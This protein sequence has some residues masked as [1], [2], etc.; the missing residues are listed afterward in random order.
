MNKLEEILGYNFK[1]PQLL[2]QALTHSSCTGNVHRNYERLE[3]LGDRVLG[4]AIA[5][6]L[7]QTFP[8]DPEGSLS[9]RFTR[10]V[11]TETVA[12][13]ARGLCLNEFIR[14]DNKEL[15]SNEN[16]LCDVAEA[17]IGAICIE[18]GFETAI[19]VVDTHWKHLIKLN[20]APQIDHK[21]S[22]Q[23]LSHQLK[24]GNPQYKV[25]RKDGSEHEPLFH[26]E[27]LVTGYGSA[28]GSGKSKK[29]AEQNAAEKLIEQ[30]KSMPIHPGQTAANA[31][32]Y[33]HK[34]NSVAEEAKGGK[35][36]K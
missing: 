31:S 22:L 9:P 15:C 13:V 36:G 32:E 21:T 17:V 30:I 11:R 1:D 27:A 16:V 23:E 4:V 35:D 28:V 29:I 26:I 7:Y 33:E 25:V 20:S 2:Q 24:G 6:L 8:A 10:L 14:A 12:E 5:H 19:N 34:P 3:F 18:A